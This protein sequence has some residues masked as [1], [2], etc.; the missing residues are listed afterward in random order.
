MLNKWA[1]QWG[2]PA[3]AIADLRNRMLPIENHL[4]PTSMADEA[5]AQMRIRMEACERGM[6]LWRNNVG[7]GKLENGSFVRWGLCND[8]TALNASVKSSDLIGIRPVLITTEHVGATVGQFVAREVKRPGW[9]YRG[10]DRETA[11]LNFLTYVLLMGGDA[12]FATGPGS[13]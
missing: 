3:E 1:Q 6:R 13:L 5:A 4:D 10:T 12:A 9:T 2:I 8:S 7:A 11:Q